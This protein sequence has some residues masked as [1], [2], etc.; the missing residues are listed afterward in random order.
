MTSR[1][2]YGPKRVY[3]ESQLS[4]RFKKVHINWVAYIC[5]QGLIGSWTFDQMF[6]TLQ[7]VAVPKNPLK[8]KLISFP[9]LRRRCIFSRA[10]TRE[11][12]I[13]KIIFAQRALSLARGLIDATRQIWISRPL[14]LGNYIWPQIE[15]Y[16]HRSEIG[17]HLRPRRHK[18]PDPE[19]AVYVECFI[20]LGMKLCLANLIIPLPYMTFWQRRESE[21]KHFVKMH[22]QGRWIISPVMSRR[23]VHFGWVNKKKR[24]R[25][26]MMKMVKYFP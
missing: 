7:L 3:I 11:Q 19:C 17:L 5:A 14:Q 2:A 9:C 1:L 23:C 16:S 26:S 24:D 22:T 20:T 13:A 25:M 18:Q 10:L 12:T 6:G 15:N 8:I 21:S 4:P